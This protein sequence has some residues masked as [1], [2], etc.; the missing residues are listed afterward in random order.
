MATLTFDSPAGMQAW[1]HQLA[2]LL[3]TGDVVA[4]VGDLGSG[5]TTLTQGIAAGWGSKQSA[6][7]PTFSLVNEYRSKRGLLTHMDMYRL[8]AR[9]LDVFPLEDY[10][11]S[12]TVTVIEWADRVQS[13]LPK[14]VLQIHFQAPS[15]TQRQIKIRFPRAWKASQRSAMLKQSH[16]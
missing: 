14:D 3:K 15:P 6:N 9:E 11:D 2:R 5:K 1:G 12:K 4:L 7:S 10:L 16:E 8:T 13:R